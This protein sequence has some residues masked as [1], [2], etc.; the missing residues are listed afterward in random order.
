MIQISIIIP[1]HNEKE[2]LERLL[3]L[4][5]GLPKCCP[6][7]IIV[8]LSKD[9][10]DGSEKLVFSSSFIFT[11]CAGKGRAVQMNTGVSE[12]TGS[13]LVFLH[14]DVIPPNSFFI[15]IVESFEAGYNAGFFSY[16]FDKKDTWLDINASFTHRDGFFTGGG[17]QCLFIKRNVFNG[18]GRFNEN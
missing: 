17:D 1:A 10:N 4:L 6:V 3:P 11:S 2:N 18:L 7:E 5:D 14:A 13:V 12:S 9:N 8:A 16:R 15:D